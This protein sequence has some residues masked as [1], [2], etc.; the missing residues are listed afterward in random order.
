MTRRKAS[1]ASALA[2]IIAA[3][4]SLKEALGRHYAV[5]RDVLEHLDRFLASRVADITPGTFTSWC[6][7]QQ[8][9]ASGVRRNRMRIV[10]NLCLYRRRDEPGCFVPDQALFPPLHQRIRPHIFTEG[11]I[12]RLLGAAE[13]LAPSPSSPLRREG[14]RLAI[15]LLY[16]TGLRRGE[17]LRLTLGDYDLREHTLLIRES[18]FHKSRLV[19]LSPDGAREIDV[20]LEARRTLGLPLSTEAPLLWNRSRGGQPYSGGGFGQGIRTLLRITAT[21]SKAGRLPRVHDFRHTF[22]VHALLRWYRAGADVQAKLPLLASY[23][24]HVSIASTQHYLQLIEPIA[25]AASERFRQQCG[26]LVV[27]PPAPGGLR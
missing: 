21:R 25:A 22:A 13:R 24:G 26:T 16:T 18:K 17:L 15:V 1:L 10:R 2:P 8:H 4:L 3:Y 5:E 11:E 27:A 6:L 19:P 9:L 12:A 7:T 14:F 20:Y 23:M